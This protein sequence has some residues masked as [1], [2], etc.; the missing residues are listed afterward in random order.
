MKNATILIGLPGSG[1]TFWIENNKN[2]FDYIFDDFSR[3]EDFLKKLPSLSGSICLSDPTLCKSSNIEKLENALNNGGWEYCKIYW[4]NNPEAALA[5][6]V[7]RDDGRQISR[8][9]IFDMSK[10]YN[11]PSGSLQIWNRNLAI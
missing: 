4:E 9:W 2:K 6:V 7:A 5:N 11:P 3:Q 1:K 10:Q 8:R